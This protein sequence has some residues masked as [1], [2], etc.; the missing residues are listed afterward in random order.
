[1]LGSRHLRLQRGPSAAAE[2]PSKGRVPGE[3]ENAK[4][5][6]RG[7]HRRRPPLERTASRLDQRQSPGD[8]ASSAGGWTSAPGGRTGKQEGVA[9][10]R[11]A[12][13]VCSSRQRSTPQ[14]LRPGQG[15]S[16]KWSLE[17]T[18]VSPFPS[19]QHYGMVGV[20]VAST[21][22]GL[23]MNCPILLLG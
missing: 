17:S 11:V 5:P 16:Q 14:L 4:R 18:P 21:R 10:A 1:M 12:G 19:K 13:S 22:F 9:G 8:C 6:A 15:F 3:E 23:S 7:V 2:L 20:R